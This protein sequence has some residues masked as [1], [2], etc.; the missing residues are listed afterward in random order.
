MKYTVVVMPCDDDY[1]IEYSEKNITI[2]DLIAK[3][4]DYSDVIDN[5]QKY[6]IRWY[7][8]AAG[9]EYHPAILVNLDTEVRIP[10]E[11]EFFIY[12][13][14]ILTYEH[15]IEIASE[16]WKVLYDTFKKDENVHKSAAE[17]ISDLDYTSDENVE[18]AVYKTIVL[19][20][21]VENQTILYELLA[22]QLDIN[23]D[24]IK[25]VIDNGYDV[26]YGYGRDFTIT[27]VQIDKKCMRAKYIENIKK[28]AKES[29]DNIMNAVTVAIE[30]L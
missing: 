2:R 9:K 12:I 21:F 6:N 30:N 26:E 28:I 24:D 5:P 18:K 29:I 4:S 23:P 19:P 7:Y 1:K 11:K 20:T 15:E 16:S 10:L 22:K 14:D 17:L 3:I 27:F 25:S 13:S 8:D